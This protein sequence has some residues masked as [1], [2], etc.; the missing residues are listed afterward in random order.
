MAEIKQ[1]IRTGNIQEEARVAEVVSLSVDQLDYMADMIAEM[2]EMSQRA[3]L[4][5]LAGVL[6]L[7][8]TEAAQQIANLRRR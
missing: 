1:K 6:Q 4:S 2:R 3:G 7:A 5:T 8:E